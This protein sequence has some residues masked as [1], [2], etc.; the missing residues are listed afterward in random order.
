MVQLLKASSYCAKLTHLLAK[1]HPHLL[2]YTL[3]NT[4]GGNTARLGAADHAHICVSV[5]MQVLGHL[6]DDEHINNA[7]H[8]FT[9]LRYTCIYVLAPLRCDTKSRFPR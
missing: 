5:L 2:A 1:L 6:N 9:Q 7:L 4:H 8:S 3:G